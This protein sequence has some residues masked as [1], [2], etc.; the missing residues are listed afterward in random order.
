MESLDRERDKKSTF[1]KLR[2]EEKEETEKAKDSEIEGERKRGEER[3]GR[4]LC[5]VEQES[6]KQ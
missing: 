3:R 6:K 5:G 2:N 1:A 4:V